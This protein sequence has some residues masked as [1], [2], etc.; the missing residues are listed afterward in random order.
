[1]MEGNLSPESATR[2][3]ARIPMYQR[4]QLVTLFC[5]V[6]SFFM[7]TPIFIVLRWDMFV[8]W[9]W[10]A[11][12]VPLWVLH[13][14]A[15]LPVLIMP[16]PPEDM[17]P[18]EQEEWDEAIRS[19]REIRAAA[20]VIMSLLIIL[21]VLVSLRLDTTID[22]SWHAVLAPWA[23]L[24][25][26]AIV[27]RLRE[28]G[29]NGA[30][31]GLPGVGWN[32][33]RIATCFCI[34]AKL[35]GTLQFWDYAFIPYYAGISISFLVLVRKCYSTEPEANGASP[36]SVACTG[37]CYLLIL[38]FWVS[39]VL[40]RLER[41]GEISAFLVMLPLFVPPYLCCC[42]VSCYVCLLGE[43]HLNDMEQAS[44][45]FEESSKVPLNPHEVV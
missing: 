1:M 42:C 19:Q 14:L 13:G 34:A 11:C 12:F 24:E 25:F 7:L 18:E 21:E 45:N 31:N 23:I 4:A 35:N 26:L 15:C 30:E 32:L 9:P 40:W 2:V 41:P 5:V 17:S 33:V 29:Q 36:Q 8:H 38:A 43:D 22:W 20:V 27:R 37:M 28:A 6:T 16:S 10:V 44:E 39:L 3:F